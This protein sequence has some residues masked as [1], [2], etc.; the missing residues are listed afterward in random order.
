MGRSRLV[1]SNTVRN[2]PKVT[3]YGEKVGGFPARLGDSPPLWVKGHRLW[4]KP[5]RPEV[6]YGQLPGKSG[7]KVTVYGENPA[8]SSL[9][10]NLRRAT[11]VR[12]HR[13]WGYRRPKSSSFIEWIGSW[14]T[15]RSPF[16]GK[17]QKGGFQESPCKVT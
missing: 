5:R 9:C 7:P 1:E 4:G 11:R 12:S 14:R 8:R 10:L 13:L 17:S 16:M 15:E 6:D 3:F 2:R